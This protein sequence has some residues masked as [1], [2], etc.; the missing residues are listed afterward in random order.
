MYNRL[1]EN[2]IK[3]KLFNG[4]VIIITGPRQSGKT[5]L[6]S[7]LAS[8]LSELSGKKIKSFNCD[9]PTD[10]EFL[11]D[12][13]LEFLKPLIASSDLIIIDEGQK[14]RNIGQS[15]KLLVDYYKDE[16]QII[17]TGS[18]SIN[19]LNSIQ[20]P[21]TGRKY[22]Y[23]L[24]PLS[25]EE[26]YGDDTL[27]MTKELESLLIFG[28]YPEIINKKSFD[29]KT[30]NLKNLTSSYLYQD[31]LEFQNIRNSDVLRTLVKA[32]ALQVGSE[33]S[34]NELSKMIG[35][36]RRTVENYVDLLEKNFVIFKLPSFSKNKR[37]ELSRSKKIYFY[38]L[39]IRNAIIN[40]FSFLD[41]R[42]DVGA[43]WEN[44]MI[45]ERLKYRAYHQVY[46][47]QYF[48]KSYD[49]GEV[50]LIEE[51][52]GKIHGYEFKWGSKNNKNK[53]PEKWLKYKP[54][55]YQIVSRDKLKGWIL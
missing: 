22:V 39:G 43:L 6:V 26:I 45:S 41:S 1:L 11:T 13:D 20:E 34:Y 50:D 4:K 16:K 49:G 12:R 52:N 47:D 21:L 25:V 8:E 36:D 37:R 48:W 33:V 18:S 15:L 29:E 17:V 7:K 30:E 3:K 42:N 51:I 32:L 38:D 19:L 40:N 2:L 46:A 14:V 54:V 53:P 27:T 55:S 28:T 5:T 10:R 35:I 23:D 9:N 31:L 24:Y 44:F